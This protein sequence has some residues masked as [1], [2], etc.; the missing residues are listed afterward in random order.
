MIP[1][2]LFRSIFEDDN[3][4]IYE[5]ETITKQIAFDSNAQTD[6]SKINQVFVTNCYF[7]LYHQNDFASNWGG[8]IF[9]S[10]FKNEKRGSLI[11]TKTTFANSYGNRGAAIFVRKVDSTLSYICCSNCSISEEDKDALGSFYSANHEGSYSDTETLIMNISS[12]VNNDNSMGQ[13]TFDLR[14]TEAYFNVCN[15]SNLNEN[16][17]SIIHSELELGLYMCT[18]SYDKFKDDQN[19]N[20]N[21]PVVYSKS[22]VNIEFSTFYELN[23]AIQTENTAS[24]SFSYFANIQKVQFENTANII[25]DKCFIDPNLLT[26]FPSISATNIISFPSDFVP[27]NFYEQYTETD[28]CPVGPFN[29]NQLTNKTTNI[30]THIEFDTGDAFNQNQYFYVYDCMF[31]DLYSETNYGEAIFAKSNGAT[32]FV[33]RTSFDN[34]TGR[35]G[36]VLCT[37]NTNLILSEICSNKACVVQDNSLGS[38]HATQ[39][40]NNINV[41]P[42]SRLVQVSVIYSQTQIQASTIYTQQQTSI[43]ACNFSNNEAEM[44][45]IDDYSDKPLSCTFSSFSY[46]NVEKNSNSEYRV[47][48]IHAGNKQLSHVTFYKNNIAVWTK[49]SIQIENS[50]FFSNSKDLVT[51]DN[52]TITLQNCYYSDVLKASSKSGSP[53]ITNTNPQ[54]FQNNF[55]SNFFESMHYTELCPIGTFFT[56]PART[57]PEN[58]TEK[59]R[60]NKIRIKCVY[61]LVSSPILSSL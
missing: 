22:N 48:F 37:E 5:N 27:P 58:C 4:A 51:E 54:Q 44:S 25:I 53:S 56:L 21:N 14:T 45:V 16:K 34:I 30:N 47:I 1:F 32:L 20:D 40:T 39:N 23:Y 50:Y 38:F 24:I 57:F 13:D 3:T 17:G 52:P 19:N 12:V 41:Q 6:P 10:N 59:D 8:C 43:N 60:K 7:E 35:Y 61:A 49:T 9:F 28:L 15:F 31:H 29:G 2:L 55:P 33:Q 36:G 46:N 42:T 18:F 26:S 11:V